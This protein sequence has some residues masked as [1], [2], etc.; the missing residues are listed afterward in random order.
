MSARDHLN[1]D[2]FKFEY[3]KTPF[4]HNIRA[5]HPDVFQGEHPVGSISWYHTQGHKYGKPMQ[6]G[7]ISNVE[8]QG[9]TKH[10]PSYRKQGIGRRLY[11]EAQKYEPQPRHSSVQS[12][13]GA[14]WAKRIG[15]PSV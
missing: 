11:N 9:E 3:Y 8:V 5:Y 15:G 10:S 2:Q 12:P 6:P 14:E 13:L 1:P 7:E 4:E